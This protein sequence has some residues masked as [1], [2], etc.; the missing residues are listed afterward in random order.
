[1]GTGLKLTGV[2]G[3]GLQTDGSG[4]VLVSKFGPVRDSKAGLMIFT[5]EV[6][7]CSPM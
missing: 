1:M 4:C 7:V 5:E 3:Y 6:C 2:G